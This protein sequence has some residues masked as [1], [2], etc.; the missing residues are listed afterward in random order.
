MGREDRAAE[1]PS[2]WP[3]VEGSGPRC[4][5]RAAD[6]APD[7][8]HRGH[9]TAPAAYAPTTMKFCPTCGNMLAIKANSESGL[10]QFACNTCPFV[11]PIE[12]QVRRVACGVRRARTRARRP[13]VS[14]TERASAARVAARPAT[15]YTS[16]ITFTRKKV[17]DVLGGQGA[18]DNVDATEGRLARGVS[19]CV[20]CTARPR[21]SR[22]ADAG[23]GALNRRGRWVR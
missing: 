15:Q 5:T 9:W 8:Q 23:L 14:D 17:D 7:S 1:W 16:K 11:R 18:W 21:G 19:A 22:G 13:L 10:Q 20:L 3:G 2:G 4:A 12:R 6:S